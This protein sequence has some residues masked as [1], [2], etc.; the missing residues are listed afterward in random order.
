MSIIDGFFKFISKSTSNSGLITNLAQRL[1]CETPKKSVDSLKNAVITAFIVTLGYIGISA[2]L[3]GTSSLGVV[4][5]DVVPLMLDISV[6]LVF[7]YAAEFSRM[8]SPRLR[9]VFLI[10]AASMVLYLIGD[11]IWA[12]LELVTHQQPFSSVADVFYVSFYPVFALGIYYIPEIPIFNHEKLKFI[13]DAAVVGITFCLIFMIFLVMPTIRSNQGMVGTTISLGYLV[14]DILLFMALVKLLFNQFKSIY[15]VFLA[16]LGMGILAMIATDG[17]YTYQSMQGTYISGGILDAGWVLSFV[18]M[19]LA[20]LLQ[21]NILKNGINPERLTLMRKFSFS[22]NLPI[23]SVIIAYI[24]LILVSY[25]SISDLLY[26]ELAVG[27]IVFLVMFRQLLT[28]NENKDLY[29]A[30]TKE[31]ERRKLVENDLKESIKEKEVLLRELNHRVKNNLQVLSSLLNLQKFYV[32]GEEAVHVLQSTQNRVTSMAIV[33]GML[34]ES[35][36]STVDFSV[37]IPKLLDDLFKIYNVG[38]GINVALSV[39]PVFMNIETAVPCGLIVSEI[40]SNSIKYAFHGG[41]GEI[42]LDFHSC[43]GGFKV[44]VGDDGA[45]LPENI[46]FNNTEGSL[47]LQLVKMLLKQ[48]DASVE[49]KRNPGTTFNIKFKELEYNKRV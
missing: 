49:L 1:P 17:I 25:Y 35:N 32:N 43:D 41:S 12:A 40:V 11:L 26:V 39:E 37:Y 48:L 45:G 31:I 22:P 46:D 27:A 10:L 15:P 23:I 8:E 18:L 24:L 47:G 5:S 33:Q 19:G 7:L 9:R 3:G 29:L 30:A 28:L 6:L 36:L 16:I 38:D 14:G 13:V 4:F 42:F 20:G 21:V 44:V 34:H 2:L